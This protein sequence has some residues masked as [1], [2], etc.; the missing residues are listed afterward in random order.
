MDRNAFLAFALSFLVLS[1]WMTYEAQHRAE[2]QPPAVAQE[3]AT[4]AAP[5][6]DPVS[7]S[8]T[9]TAKP[10]APKPEAAVPAAPTAAEQD[11]DVESELFHAVLSSRGAGIERYELRQ[12]S[13]AANEGGGPVVLIDR[14]AGEAPAFATPLP[15]L[16]FGDLGNALFRVVSSSAREV[17][18]EYTQSSV[19][20]RKTFSFEDASYR[21]RLRLEIEN[22]AAAA[23]S[24]A[25]GVVLPER[26]QPGSDFRELTLATLSAGSVERAPLAGFGQPGFFSRDPA[27]EQE[28]VGDVEWAGAYSHYFLTAVMPDAPRDV[29]VRWFAAQPGEEAHITLAHPPAAILPGTALSRDYGVYA[30]PKEP[31]R[32]EL[33]GAQLERSIDLGWSWVAPLT[34]AFVWLLKACYAVIPN[35][36]VAIILLTVLVRLATAPLAAR[37]M[38]SMKRMGELQ[39]KLKE[40]QEKYKDDRQQQSQAMMALYKEAGVNPL[41]GC[42]PILL[43]FPVFIGL[44]YALQSSIDLRQAEFGLWIDDLSRPETLFTI[45]GVGWP[46]RVLP[47]LMTLSMVLQQKMT[48]TTSMDPV[49][50]RTMMI[51]MPIMFFFMFYGFPSGLV[52][53]WF[54]S[55]LLAILQQVY[56]NRQM[57]P[58]TA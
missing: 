44:Y 13:A 23:I 50:A 47:I 22:G 43:Q 1:L 15:E 31:E 27:L 58:K 10:E 2:Q 4:P 36:G 21:F 48:P 28:F 7:P 14:G 3:S 46:V 34:R 51:V 11:I 8:A 37:Q 41:G 30:G 53:Y 17:V 16:G 38:R 24:P 9:A 20:V 57:G 49:Q 5:A 19:T 56:L 39:P 55:N 25:F 18:F 12:Y 45:P 29:R 40:L 26:A 32:L 54:V 33:A 52:L 6:V 35:Y 42:L